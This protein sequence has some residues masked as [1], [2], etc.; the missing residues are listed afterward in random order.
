M[1]I[2]QVMSPALRT[3]TSTLNAATHALPRRRAEISIT[4]LQE[5]ARA[6]QD[7]YL[8]RFRYR[9]AD[10]EETDREAEPHRL[11]T[12]GALWYLQA[13]D[14]ARKDWRVFRLDRMESFH[15]TSWQF[16]PRVAPPSNF[17]K[18]LCELY[19]CTLRVE[20]EATEQQILHRIPAPYHAELEV[21]PYGC[22]FLV[23]ANRWDDLAWHLLWV[24]RDL[25]RPILL[26]DSPEAAECRDA[27]KRIAANANE[28]AQG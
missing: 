21:T 4:L 9:R 8:V 22:R 3:T 25:G 7:H 28:I 10:G 20:I 2:E 11:M 17:E 18:D 24:S 12:Q 19:S 6:Q 23:G 26:P 14:R 1:K 13:F 16:T 5:L 15:V 27:M